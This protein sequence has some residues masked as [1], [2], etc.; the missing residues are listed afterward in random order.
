MGPRRYFDLF[1]LVVG[2]GYPVKRKAADKVTRRTIDKGSSQPRIPM[3]PTSYLEREFVFAA[4]YGDYAPA[5]S[6]DQHG[7]G[8]DKD[9]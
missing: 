7:N 4:K 6:Q 8:D 9:V 5:G 2:S 3:L 1:S